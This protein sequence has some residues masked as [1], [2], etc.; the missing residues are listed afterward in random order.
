MLTSFFYWPADRELGGDT[1]P[2]LSSAHHPPVE[3]EY[4]WLSVQEE[5]L[6]LGVKVMFA[7]TIFMFMGLVW[8]IVITYDRDSA[9]TID[10]L[11]ATCV[12]FFCSAVI[13]LWCRYSGGTKETARLFIKQR[14][15]LLIRQIGNWIVS[16]M[17]SIFLTSLLCVSVQDGAEGVQE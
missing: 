5:D 11:C 16:V 8:V 12:K 15:V 4:Q 14:C 17:I 10:V 3:V 1:L 7:T 6:N 13:P 2:D 9:G